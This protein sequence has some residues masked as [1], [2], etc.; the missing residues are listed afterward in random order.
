MSK[1]TT[2]KVHQAFRYIS[3]PFLHDYVMKFCKTTVKEDVNC[4][5][6][7]NFSNLVGVLMNSTIAN[8]TCI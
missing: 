7:T 5:K 8:F 3:F 4:H 2:L 1:S 6:T